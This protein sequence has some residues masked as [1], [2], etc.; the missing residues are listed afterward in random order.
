MAALR[1]IRDRAIDSVEARLAW[2]LLLSALPGAI[3]G[4]LLAGF[5]ED[6]LGDP[7]LIG[8]NLIVFALVLEWADRST[9]ERVSDDFRRRDA[10]DH[11]RRPRRWR[12][13]RGSHVPGSRSQPGAGCN[14]TARRPPG[15]RSS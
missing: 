6:E 14:S 5:I 4:A 13:R 12:S 8:V 9:G 11:G 10:A 7:V 1:S 15:S 2:L 3:V